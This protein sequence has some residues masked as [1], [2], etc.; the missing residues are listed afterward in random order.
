[1]LFRD[2]PGQESSKE[3]LAGLI[4]DDRI[5]HAI[6]FTG[7]Q[8]NGK[9]AFAMAFASAL[10]CEEK[11]GIEVCGVCTHCIKSLK[12]IH[13]DLHLSFPV[14]SIEGKK[15]DATTSNDFLVPFRSYLTEE[16]FKGIDAW[17]KYINADNKP[18]NINVTECNQ[19]I[20]SLGLRKYEGR[21]KIQIIFGAE[22]LSKEGNRLLKL[23][24]EPTPD[25]IIILISDFQEQILN[26]IKSRCQ[27]FKIPPF[28][29]EEINAYLEPKIFDEKQREEIVRLAAGNLKMALDLQQEDESE[30]DE[31]LLDIFRGAYTSNITKMLKLAD[32][33]SQMN[34]KEM[35]GFCLYTLHFLK[36]YM[37]V[38]HL[39]A[40]DSVRLSG[41]E[42][43]TALKMT[44][45]ISVEM[46]IAIAA[47]MEENIVNINRNANKKI[48]WT[49]TMFGIEEIFAKNKIAS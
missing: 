8:G 24:E 34:K 31:I 42:K 2:I 35:Q 10:L 36:E 1:M 37:R 3:Y 41:K 40:T 11:E 6:L 47:V 9:L 45:S 26:T 15:R 18:I 39:N 12:Y 46:A 28:T 25:T 44:R 29:D 19:I 14:S 27:I 16:I 23:I 43:S 32:R 38:V 49:S 13:P 22:Y 21:Y 48:L 30:Y 7:P 4:K 33:L 20:K 17:A 5:P